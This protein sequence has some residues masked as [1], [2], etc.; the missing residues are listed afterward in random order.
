MAVMDVYVNSTVR[1]HMLNYKRKYEAQKIVSK[2]LDGTSYVQNVGSAI[3]RYEVDVYCSSG[4]NR[5]AMDLA[6]NTC[7]EISII[8]RD[9]HEVKGFIEDA[10]IEWKEWT[11]GHGVGHFV[12]I[13]E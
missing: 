8:L 12:L 6:S 11:D 4:I 10:E 9:G 13:E 2:A 1:G 7:A 3:T 5:D